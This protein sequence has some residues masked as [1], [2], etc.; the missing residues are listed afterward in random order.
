[1]YGKAQPFTLAMTSF[2]DAW[3]KPSAIRAPVC[4][5]AKLSSSFVNFMSNG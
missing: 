1:M 4:P 5:R 3:R 2:D